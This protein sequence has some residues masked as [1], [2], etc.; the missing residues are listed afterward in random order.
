[1]WGTVGK[2]AVGPK[3]RCHFSQPTRHQRELFYVSADTLQS[4]KR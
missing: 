2:A 1:M 4:I 3:L